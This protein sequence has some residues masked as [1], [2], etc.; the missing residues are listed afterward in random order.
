MS[1]K[2]IHEYVRKVIHELQFEKSFLDPLKSILDAIGWNVEKT[3]NLDL[4]FV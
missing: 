2:I 1:I 3:V 4:F